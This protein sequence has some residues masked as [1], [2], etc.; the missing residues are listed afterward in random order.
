MLLVVWMEP[1]TKTHNIR[2]MLLICWKIS[3]CRYNLALIGILL[4]D[5]VG[6]FV[7]CFDGAYSP[8]ATIIM[9]SLNLLEQTG[10]IDDT[11]LH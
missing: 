8:Y 6:F 9:L 3:A 5:D 7:G 4:G 2:L 10:H 1:R 11:I